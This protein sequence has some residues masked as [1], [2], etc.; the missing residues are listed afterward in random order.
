MV[1]M[2]LPRARVRM[3]VRRL[4]FAGHC[5]GSYQSAMQPLRH[6]H[7]SLLLTVPDGLLIQGTFNDYAKALLKNHG[8]H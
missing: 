5:W 4:A 7:E 3:D 8:G 6:S 2:K 1:Q